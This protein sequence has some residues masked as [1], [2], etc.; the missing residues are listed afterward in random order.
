M[1]VLLG[2]R[3][4]IGG[5]CFEGRVEEK[6]LVAVLKDILRLAGLEDEEYTVNSTSSALQVRFPSVIGTSYVFTLNDKAEER[7]R[8]VLLTAK[9][10]SA[11]EI[12]RFIK[13]KLDLLM[14]GR[15]YFCY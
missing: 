1:A 12:G 4:H 14:I 2:N 8:I 6:E 5:W 15:G 11:Y 3:E 7:T 10:F 13:N 9:K